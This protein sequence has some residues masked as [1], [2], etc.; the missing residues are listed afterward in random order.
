MN[1]GIVGRH[2]CKRSFSSKLLPSLRSTTK[3]YYH[4][5]IIDLR[6]KTV[7]ASGGNNMLGYLAKWIEDER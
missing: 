3:S 4:V 2:K 1:G 5:F 6:T 7:K